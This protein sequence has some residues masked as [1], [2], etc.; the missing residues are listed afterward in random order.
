MSRISP[1]A[2]VPVVEFDHESFMPGGGE[3]GAEPECVGVQTELVGS[4]GEDAAAKTLRRLLEAEGGLSGLLRHGQRPTSIKTRIIAN[5]QQLVRVDREA[6]GDLKGPASERLWRRVQSRLPGVDGV[7]V[8]DYGK[9]VVT[10]G[11][12]DRVREA[13]RHRGIWLSLDP[14]PVH[15]LDL[16]GLSLLTP[17]RKEVFELAG[18]AD[19]APAVEPLRDAM[20]QEVAARLLEELRPALLLV[21]LGEHGMLLCQRG[22]AAVHIPT[23][24][25]EVFDVSGAGDTVIGVF[26][27][28]IVAGRRRWRRRSCR[29][30]RRGWWWGSWARR[31]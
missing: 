6:R 14:K 7:I 2:P 3:C 1:E 12:L 13:C 25:R 15:R 30:T 20:L 9:G 4:V 22:Q 28:A 10:Q 31:W 21:T 24:A 19:L 16:S 8:G 29:T 18:V 17:N 5:R 26:T 11:L 23:R 27:L